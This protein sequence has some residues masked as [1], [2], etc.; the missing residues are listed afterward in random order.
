MNQSISWL[1]A[2]AVAALATAAQGAPASKSTTAPVE[3]PVAPP[4]PAGSEKPRFRPSTGPLDLRVGELLAWLR[5][6]EPALQSAFVTDADGLPVASADARPDHVAISSALMAT[7]V[8]VRQN[9]QTDARRIAVT[10]QP[11]EILHVVTVDTPA[12]VLAV[13]MV[14][15]RPLPDSLLGD[16][17]SALALITQ[18]F[19]ESNG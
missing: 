8:Q 1:D 11:G 10:T 12:G 18:T 13:G 17:R 19:G 3:I 9:L 14:A 16:A 4:P 7:L 2:D 5:E 6:R 15:A